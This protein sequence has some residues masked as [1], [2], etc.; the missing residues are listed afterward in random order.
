[1]IKIHDIK[2]ILEIPDVSIYFYYILIVL[3]FVSLG[4]GVYFIY[5]FIKP[6]KQ[7]KEMKYYKILQNLEFKNTKETAYTISKYANYLAKDDRQI[8]LLEELNND[9]SSY[10]YKKD[11]DLQFSSNIKTKFSVFMETL[12][13]R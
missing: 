7:T 5:Q 4:V 11:I 9:L 12:D 13:V 2:P 8:R 1:M 10:K 3:A 6:K